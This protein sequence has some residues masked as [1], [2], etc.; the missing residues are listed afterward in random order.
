MVIA[1][2]AFGSHAPFICKIE[3]HAVKVCSQID[4]SSEHMTGCVTTADGDATDTAFSHG[5]VDD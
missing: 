5:R 4:Q 1:L 3:L 2:G